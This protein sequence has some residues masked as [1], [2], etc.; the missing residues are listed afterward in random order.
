MGEVPNGHATARALNERL[1]ALDATIRQWAVYCCLVHADR[2]L[3][4]VDDVANL[5]RW[6]CSRE[7]HRTAEDG[8]DDPSQAYLRRVAARAGDR[9]FHSSARTGLSGATGAARRAS[10]ANLTTTALTA[11]LGREPTSREVIDAVNAHARTTRVDPVK[12]GALIRDVGDLLAEVLPL[13]ER[14][15][16]REALDE[17]VHARISA[18]LAIRRTTEVCRA[19]GPALGEVADLWLSGALAEPPSIPTVAEIAELSSRRPDEVRELLDE[20]RVVAELVCLELGL[21]PG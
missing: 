13:D 4:H 12:Q 14:I 21:G 20:C 10:R 8:L 2:R 11:T 18:E 1:R 7:L 15:P 16:A 9:Y 3:V 6:E 5:M 19:M 17:R